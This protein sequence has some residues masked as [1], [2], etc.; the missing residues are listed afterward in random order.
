MQII[1]HGKLRSAHIVCRACGCEFIAEPEDIFSVNDL[2]VCRSNHFACRCP[3][4]DQFI[5]WYLDKPN[6]EVLSYE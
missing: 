2:T 1:K 3:D 5:D 4:C 6:Q